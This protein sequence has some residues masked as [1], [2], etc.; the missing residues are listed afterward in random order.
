MKNSSAFALAKRPVMLGQEK[1]TMS[2]IPIL[3]I[4]IDSVASAIAAEQGGAA[5]VELC[6]NLFEGGTT[7]SVG[8]VCQTLERV[9]IKVNAIIRPRGGDFLYSDDEF[10]VMQHDIITLKEMGVNGVVIGMLNADG[11]IDVERSSRLIELARPLEV[12]YHRAFDVTADPFRSLDDIIGLSAERLLTS[13]QEPSVL[14]GVEL[15]AELV[16]RAGD[17]I[18]IMPGA[19]ITEKN[20]PRIMRETGAK[21][22][23]VTG[24]APV[25]STMEFR[26]ERCFMGKALYPP[27]FSLKVT[28]ADKIRNYIKLLNNRE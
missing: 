21:E 3:E 7:P 28:N 23:H 27:E 11:T 9:G 1:R 16:R 25:Q 2:D 17:D 18:I 20:L 4:C 14:E 22:F 24:S 10:A 13:G 15:I 12:T 26:N 5:R 6:Q 19:G 8:T